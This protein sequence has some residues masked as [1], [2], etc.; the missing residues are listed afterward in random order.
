MNYTQTFP[1]KAGLKARGSKLGHEYMSSLIAAVF[2]AKFGALNAHE[3]DTV[4]NVPADGCECYA[5]GDPQVYGTMIE[6][7]AATAAT[8]APILNGVGATARY[9]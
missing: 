9:L 8:S 4:K 1:G 5:N 6:G 2:P 7:A 3:L